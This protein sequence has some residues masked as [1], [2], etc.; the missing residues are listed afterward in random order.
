MPGIIFDSLDIRVYRKEVISGPVT[1]GLRITKT[2]ANEAVTTFSTTIDSEPLWNG[3]PTTFDISFE[4][5]TSKRTTFDLRSNAWEFH[6]ISAA[7]T[8][9][10]TKDLLITDTTIEVADA[11]VLA[12]PNLVLN[13]PGVIYINGEKITYYTVTGNVLGQL[14]RGVWGTGAPSVHAIGSAVEDASKNQEIPGIVEETMVDPHWLNP[15]MFEL[16]GIIPNQFEFMTAS[17]PM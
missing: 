12:T 9:V 7:N 15:G 1:E 8:T 2:M 6:R 4:T 14:R 17:P 10:L 5:P 3:L 16:P 11:T 13:Y